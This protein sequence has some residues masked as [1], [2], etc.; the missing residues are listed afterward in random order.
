MKGHVAVPS[1]VFTYM[2]CIVVYMMYAYK[3]ERLQQMTAL[4]ALQLA[5]RLVGGGRGSRAKGLQ[6][7]PE[8]GPSWLLQYTDKIKVQ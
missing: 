8:P 6:G 2:H 7:K 1:H 3:K 5:A 4:S